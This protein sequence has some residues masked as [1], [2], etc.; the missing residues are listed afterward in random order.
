VIEVVEMVAE[1]DAGRVVEEEAQDGEEEGGVEE[2]HRYVVEECMYRK[3]GI[4][5]NE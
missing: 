5:V 2:I 1:E 4:P 3:M